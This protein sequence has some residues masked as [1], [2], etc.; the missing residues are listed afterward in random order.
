MVR[1]LWNTLV[2][3]NSN[4]LKLVSNFTFL[5]RIPFCDTTSVVFPQDNT[6]N[7]FI[8]FYKNLPSFHFTINRI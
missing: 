7:N 3:T 2:R 1:A 4:Q 8:L 5:R 6:I